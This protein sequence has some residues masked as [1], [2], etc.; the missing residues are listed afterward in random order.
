MLLARLAVENTTYRFD[1]PFTYIVP[2]TLAAAVRP[3][4][5]VTVPFGTGNRTRVGMVLELVREAADTAKLKEI[6]SVLD[7][8]PLL[9]EEMLSLAVWMKNRYYC[10][11][12]EAIKLMIPTGIGYKIVNRYRMSAAFK[13]Y[14]RELFDDLSWQIIMT[15]TGV[16][17]G[18]TGAQLFQK[19]GIDEKSDA[20]LSLLAQGIVI[21]ENAASR[22]LND[23]TSKMICA[24]PDFEG[25][26]SPKQQTVYDTLC[27]VGTVSVR[28]IGY[29][30][31][32]SAAVIKALS[33]KGAAEI[34]EVERFRR[35]K[36]NG[37]QDTALP[38][39]LSDEQAREARAIIRECDADDPAVAL[40]YGVTGSGKTAVFMHVIRHVLEKGRSV[41]VTVPEISLTPQTL[42]VFTAAFGDTVAVFHSGLS[43]GERMDEWKRV[44]SGQAKIVVGTRSAVFAPVQDLGLIV[45]DEEQEGTYKSESSP[46][47]HAREVAKFRVNFHKAYCLLCSATPSVESYFMAKSGKYHYH[48]LLNRYGDAIVPQVRLVDM[49]TEDLYR[50]KPLISTALAHAVSENIREGKQSI[51]L[52]NRRGYHTYAVCKNCKTVVS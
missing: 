20:L 17:Q 1:K 39:K 32:V 10:T 15:L 7:K 13:D 36:V 18:M 19:L 26:L 29:F 50:G 21:R 38:E 27:E 22:N 44:R 31:G 37:L 16:K 12:F 5:R 28:E 33:D 52:L 46:R 41:I 35:P 2:H 25:T 48:A 49:N 6:L 14:D 8:E 24:V 51:L 11:L 9:N 40:L 23:S 34:F 30:T 4:V 45:M 43:I 42:A 47:Y 3:G